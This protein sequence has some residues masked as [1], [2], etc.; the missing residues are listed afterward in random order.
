MSEEVGKEKVVETVA[1]VVA[2]PDVEAGAPAAKRV[3][4]NP[5]DMPV[6]EVF[7]FISFNLHA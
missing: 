2:A 4:D 1:E 7:F 6:F 5:T 3:E